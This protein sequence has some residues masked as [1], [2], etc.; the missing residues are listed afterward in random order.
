MP[1][2]LFR[3]TKT[4]S[5][6]TKPYS[7]PPVAS[8]INGGLRLGYYIFAFVVAK[9]AL[10]IGS[11]RGQQIILDRSFL[12]FASD[13]TRSRIPFSRLPQW[14][15]R[16]LVPTG[17]LFYLDASPTT[18]VSRK[19]ELSIEKATFLQRAYYETCAAVDATLLD[20]DGTADAVFVKVLEYI[21]L[22]YLARI[23][24]A[25]TATG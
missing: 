22:E 2:Q 11:R 25:Q 14:L 1:H 17:T 18:V 16:L 21:S 4:A 20:G 9:F 7:E 10:W 5:N 3:R 6:Y 23:D 12:D 19:G 13:P 15:V 8:R 24:K